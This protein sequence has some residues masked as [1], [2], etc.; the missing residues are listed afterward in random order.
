MTRRAKY[1]PDAVAKITDAIRMGAT[2]E[3]AS[4]YA[5][6]AYETF[7]MWRDKYPAFSAAIKAAEGEA[8]M[9]WLTMIE[10]AA[11]NG[12][13]QAAAWKLERRYPEQYGRQVTDNQHSGDITIT[14][15][16]DE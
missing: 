15:K 1:T 16:Y 14:V 4:N 11:H 8:A 5:G 12:T 7:R 6:I 3:L 2:Y 13:W 9:K 10:D